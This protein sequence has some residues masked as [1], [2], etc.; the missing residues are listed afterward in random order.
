M[1]PRFGHDFGRVRVHADAR[2]AESARAVGALAYTVGRHIVFDEGQYAPA[3]PQGR[4]LLAHELTHAA[5]QWGATDPPRLEL[6][7][8]GSTLER[9]AER[10]ADIVTGGRGG[11]GLGSVQISAAAIARV[12]R[13]RRGA[14]AGCGICMMDPTGSI[15]G[16]IAHTE[17]QAA[18]FA[19]HPDMLSERPLPGVSGAAIDLSYEKRLV[20]THALFIGEIK[21]LDDA[22]VQAQL[23]R[24]QLQDYYREALLSGQWDEIFRMPDPP[25]PG[26]LPFPNAMRPPGCPQQVI[27]VQLTEPGLYQYF[28]EPPWSQLVKDPACKCEPPGPPPVPVPVPEPVE[29]PM[30]ARPPGRFTLRLPGDIDWD[31]IAAG[32]AALVAALAATAPGRLGAWL[33][34]ALGALLR[35][36]GFSIA[37]A[38]AAA[39]AAAGTAGPPAGKPAGKP[40]TRPHPGRGP[41]AGP[42]HPPP[43]AAEGPAQGGKKRTAKVPPVKPGGAGKSFQVS[44]YEGRN[45]N[46]IV[47]GAVYRVVSAPGTPRQKFMVV[48]ATRVTKEKDSTTAEFT[49]LLECTR[50]SCS[51]GGNFYTVT[52]PHRATA[53]EIRIQLEELK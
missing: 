23:G 28:C 26:P 4:R 29:E 30:P 50:D 14:A 15:A 3:S 22:G 13:Q 18:F 1:E 20:G 47:E 48:Q 46:T 17:V 45:L 49:S 6:E 39:S 35:W 34:T 11:A 19:L 16:G 12:Q 10:N 5:Q 40:V 51:P 8:A 33:G 38:E 27:E 9:E 52:H 25:P 21:P 41:A 53:E 7:P 42:P 43:K 31:A 36:L 2:G 44:V 37:F 32:L 24:R